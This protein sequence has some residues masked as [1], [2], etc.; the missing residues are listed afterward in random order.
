MSA[1][2]DLKLITIRLT[3]LLVE[4]RGAGGLLPSPGDRHDGIRFAHLH[5]TRPGTDQRDGLRVG[6]A[7]GD[8]AIRRSRLPRG[9]P[10]PDFLGVPEKSRRRRGFDEGTLR[11]HVHRVKSA[12]RQPGHAHALRIDLGIRNDVV[13][14]IVTSTVGAIIVVLLARLIA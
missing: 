6:Q 11:G 3:Q 9:H 13:R 4:N 10:R 5:E 12:P 1:R 14:Q 7:L 2:V 8:I